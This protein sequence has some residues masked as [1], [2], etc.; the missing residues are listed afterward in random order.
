[1]LRSIRQLAGAA[2]AGFGA[3]T[4]MLTP[5]LAQPPDT[6]DLTIEQRPIAGIAEAASGSDLKVTA[7]VDRANRT[8]RTGESVTLFVKAN[9]DAY[10]T[11]LNVGTSGRVHVIFPNRHQQDNRVFAHQVVQIPGPDAQFRLRASGPPGQELI[12]VFATLTPG[13]LLRPHLMAEAG[14]FQRFASDSTEELAR[15]LQVE[16]AERHPNAYATTTHTFRIVA[17]GAELPRPPAPARLG[18]AEELYR[19]AEASFYGDRGRPDYRTA[20]QLYLKAAEGGHVLAMYRV[21]RIHEA[22]M[23]VDQNPAEAQRWYRKAASLGNTQAM[24]RLAHMH[25]TGAGVRRDFTEAIA[26]LSRAANAGD[27]SA[28]VNLC[29]MYD[30]GKG[31]AR[32]S[33]EAARYLLGSVRAGAWSAQRELPRLSEQSRREVQVQLKASG[34]YHGPI[35]G[36]IG[37]LTQQALADYALKG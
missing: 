8:Y 6:K 29:L 7:W 13:T 32:N 4:A 36:Q 27:G 5:A 11:I 17:D 2:A 18:S 10:L 1:M 37:P 20:L 16:L 3:I 34:H 19:Q 28:M 21:G 25:G 24:V 23:D 31:V 33:R 22:G 15:D 35:N 30:E 9:R 26:W 14:A 12:K